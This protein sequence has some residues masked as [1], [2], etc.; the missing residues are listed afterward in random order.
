MRKEWISPASRLAALSSFICFVRGM[1][2][3]TEIQP[4]IASATMMVM[5]LSFAVTAF[6][7]FLVIGNG[8]VRGGKWEN[9]DLYAEN[10]PAFVGAMVA[11][12]FLYSLFCVVVLLGNRPH[13][14]LLYLYLHAL[15][16]F[17][18]PCV[19]G[20][21]QARE[22]RKIPVFFIPILVLFLY[23]IFRAFYQWLA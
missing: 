22:G 8:F 12:A 15:F 14:Y 10:S 19:W 20:I 1:S 13:L 23:F 17:W 16:I 21:T 7:A 11:T 6:L 2:S 5:S 3:A 9:S 18:G 4:G